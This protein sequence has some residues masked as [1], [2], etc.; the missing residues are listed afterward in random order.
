[1]HQGP[2]HPARPCLPLL[3]PYLLALLLLQGVLTFCILIAIAR[4]LR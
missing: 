2:P 3:V 1:M 4:H